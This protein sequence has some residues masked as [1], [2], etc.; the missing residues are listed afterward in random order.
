[1]D[2]QYLKNQLENG[3][4]RFIEPRYFTARIYCEDDTVRYFSYP[5]FSNEEYKKVEE[6]FKGSIEFNREILKII[7]YEID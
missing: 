2:A 1:M 4:R 6:R 7:Y 5:T 3:L